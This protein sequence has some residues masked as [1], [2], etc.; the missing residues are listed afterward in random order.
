MRRDSS[1]NVKPR[2]Q[3]WGILP[4]SEDPAHD[5]LCET[6][7]LCVIAVEFMS[8]ATVGCQAQVVTS[9]LVLEESEAAE[10]EFRN[11]KR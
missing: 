7:R 4:L 11:T 5:P 6:C 2:P 9:G 8:K 1:A 10:D 3:K